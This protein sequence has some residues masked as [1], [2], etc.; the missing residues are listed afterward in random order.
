M[1]PE[2]HCEHLRHIAAVRD[3]EPAAAVAA[4]RAGVRQRD[5]AAALGRG[6][7]HIRRIARAAEAEDEIDSE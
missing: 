2:E 5:V 7:E 1:T 3:E 6:R 4:L